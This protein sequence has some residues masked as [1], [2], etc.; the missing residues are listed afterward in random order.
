MHPF[1]PWTGVAVSLEAQNGL[2]GLLAYYGPGN[3][4]VPISVPPGDR[5]DGEEGDSEKATVE[6][7]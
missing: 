4:V 5:L 3:K 6:G 1:V 2:L 7:M